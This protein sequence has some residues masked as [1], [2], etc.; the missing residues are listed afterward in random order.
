MNGFSLSPGS[1]GE[2]GAGCFWQCFSKNLQTQTL[3]LGAAT[4]LPAVFLDWRAW[5]RTIGT[6]D[7]AVARLGL[8][9]LVAT[10]A[11]VKPLAGVRW[12][13]LGL[14]KPAQGACNSRSKFDGHGHIVR[15]K[16]EVI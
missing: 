15:V 4:T 12:H 9:D 7:A 2:P 5:H 6:E 11:V 16:C 1:L 13:F 3:L 10:S 8:D 14:R